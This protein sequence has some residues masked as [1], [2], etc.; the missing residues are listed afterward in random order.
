MKQK[1][2]P[3]SYPS[4]R[5]GGKGWGGEI[6]GDEEWYMKRKMAIISLLIILSGIV[7]LLLG[8]PPA[9]VKVRP[10]E[11][12]VEMYG[13]PPYPE[14]VWISGHWKHKKEEWVW[15]RGHWARPP[16]LHAVWIPGYWEPRGGGWIWIPGHWEYR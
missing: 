1:I 10:P 13:P 14:A 12:R 8:C 11:P 7:V 9:V 16:R 2:A 4:P 5:G 6:K 15:V 3:H